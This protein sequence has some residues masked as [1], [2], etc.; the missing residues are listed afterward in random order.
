V[1]GNTIG[2]LA[3]YDENN[4]LDRM[5]ALRLW[6]VGS[7]WFSTDEDSKGAV[8]PGQLADLSVLTA[9]YFSVPDEEIKRL[10]S[11]LTIVGG[12]PV[13]AAEEFSEL[14]PALPPIL[15]EWSPV[16]VYSGYSKQVEEP[17]SAHFH[18]NRVHDNLHRHADPQMDS[19]MGCLCWAF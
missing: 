5:E 15:P 9:D 6:T 19:G 2:G 11:V 12:K 1:T 10:E 7:S 3:M 8:V 18:C 4:R 13:Y 16:A 17:L 14:A